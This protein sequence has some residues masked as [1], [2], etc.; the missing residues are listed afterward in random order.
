MGLDAFVRCNCVKEGKA[1]FP[2]FMDK[3]TFD[4][5]GYVEL[6]PSEAANEE[7]EQKLDSWQ[8]C[9][10]EDRKFAREHI[11]NWSGYRFFQQSLG[12]LG[13]E[14]F[15]NLKEYLPDANGGSLPANIAKI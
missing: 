7:L 2:P 4:T 13:W 6:I 8:W 5:E 15:P 10:H 9:E 1:A 3:V 12:K 14:H 11:S